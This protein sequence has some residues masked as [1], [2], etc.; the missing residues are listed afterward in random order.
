MPGET[1]KVGKGKEIREVG[2]EEKGRNKET[3]TTCSL[4]QAAYASKVADAN[5]LV[6]EKKSI[7]WE[8]PALE[9]PGIEEETKNLQSVVVYCSCGRISRKGLGMCDECWLLDKPQEISGY[10]YVEKDE[11]NVDR[12]WFSLV[13]TD[14]YCTPITK[15]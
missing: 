11:K 4:L 15:H 13:N 8:E 9:S 14:L 3:F 7:L 12:Y 6:N 10:L 5:V 2:V 1:D